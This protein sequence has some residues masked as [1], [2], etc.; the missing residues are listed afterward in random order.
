MTM[1]ISRYMWRHTILI[2][3]FFNEIYIHKWSN[4]N[5]LE[6]KIEFN[7]NDLQ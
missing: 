3:Q 2:D 1:S 6:F 7:L 5:E 4:F